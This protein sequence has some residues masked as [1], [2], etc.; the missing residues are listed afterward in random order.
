[1]CDAVAP[2]QSQQNASRAAA[3]GCAVL[4]PSKAAACILFSSALYIYIYMLKDDSIWG[5]NLQTANMIKQH[6]VDVASSLQ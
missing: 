1:M 4:R 6:N 3:E 5:L 2:W